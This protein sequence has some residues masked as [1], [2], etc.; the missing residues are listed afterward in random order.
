MKEL[1]EIGGIIEFN[2]SSN[3]RLNNLTDIRNCPIKSY[4]ESGINCV[5]GTDGY[6]IYG[7]DS[8][9]EQVASEYL[10]KLSP[11]DFYKMKEIEEKIIKESDNYIKEKSVEFEKFLNGRTIRE[12]IS[13][14]ANNNILKRNL[15]TKTYVNSSI[16][17]KKAFE[18]KVIKG[19]PQ[20]KVPVVIAGGSFNS[21]GRETVIDES[22][23]EI[24]S[25]LI[26]NLNSE[27]T[28]FV[29]GHRM[30]GYEKAILD[31]A[32]QKNKNFEIKAIVP[33]LVSEDVKE[34][35][36]DDG[37]NGI[38]VSPINQEAGIY[39][40]FNY[41]IF[42]RQNS[43]V[44]AFDGNSPVTNLIQEAKNGKAKANIYVNTEVETLKE[45][46]KYLTGYVKEF[47]N[48][49]NLAEMIL[50]DN[51]ELRAKNKLA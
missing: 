12:A 30:Q 50:R 1:I 37:V 26:D 51:P 3:V 20:D 24:L 11:D 42:E 46:A 2:L 22:A 44:L 39:K 27:K 4:I 21:F 36:L 34:K 13:E 18:Y 38:C 10:L 40:S 35:L 25:E 43:I 29:V 33:K 5:Q 8:I 17:S 9:E 23:K 6:G 16:D 41:E 28:Y 45:K 15:Q 14:E 32:K 19:L 7:T 48:K 49:E 47:N 31:I